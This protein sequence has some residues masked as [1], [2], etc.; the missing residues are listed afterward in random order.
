MNNTFFSLRESRK[1]YIRRDIA[2]ADRHIFKVKSSTLEVHPHNLMKKQHHHDELGALEYDLYSKLAK[3]FSLKNLF[4]NLL[5]RSDINTFVP[6]TL[7][8]GDGRIPLPFAY[9]ATLFKMDPVL[10]DK[11]QKQ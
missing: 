1:E 3:T 9:S 4:T 10:S 8:I 2:W 6:R 11:C 7:L 5:L